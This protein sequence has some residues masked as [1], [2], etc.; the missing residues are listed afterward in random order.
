MDIHHLM[1][2]TKPFHPKMFLCPLCSLR[3]WCHYLQSL[4]C[5]WICSI[6]SF[7]GGSDNKESACNAGHSGLIPELGR[8]LEKGMATHSR[9]LAWGVPWPEE[10]DRLQSMGSQRVRYDW[11]SDIY[12][13]PHFFLIPHPIIY[14]PQCHSLTLY[15]LIPC[16]ITFGG[17]VFI[18]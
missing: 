5:C 8:S 16:A 15:F 17:R 3:K 14:H 9:I 18:M 6:L 4:H 12:T 7:P 13:Q 10:P 1:S 11:A 2:K